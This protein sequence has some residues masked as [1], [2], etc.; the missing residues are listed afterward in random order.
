MQYLR[1]VLS[2]LSLTS[3]LRRGFC[4]DRVW[5]GTR[6]KRFSDFAENVHISVFWAETTENEVRIFIKKFRREI[7]RQIQNSKFEL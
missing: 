6:T 5:L 7:W 4:K 1:I 3:H 2:Q